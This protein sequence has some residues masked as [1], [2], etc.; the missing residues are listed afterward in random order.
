MKASEFRALPDGDLRQRLTEVQKELR[1]L[2]LKTRQGA[3]E[4]PHRIGRL[5]RDVA[6]ILTV[7]REASSPAAAG[8]SSVG[9]P[10]TADTSSPERILPARSQTATNAKESR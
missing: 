2:R 8:T 7:L 9:S 10:S 6:R 5:R 3:T 4:Q 1:D